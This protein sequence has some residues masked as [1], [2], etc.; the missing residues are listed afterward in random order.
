MALSSL[1]QIDD[2][3]PDPVTADDHHSHRAAPQ[4][5]AL[6]IVLVGASRGPPRSTFRPVFST[7]R[8]LA[9]RT[10]VAV[11][12]ANAL[13]VLAA[14]RGVPTRW[15]LVGSGLVAALFV[16]YT[17]LVG[18]LSW[19]VFPG[20]STASGLRQGVADGSPAKCSTTRCRSGNHTLA[21]CS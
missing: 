3:L 8:S 11:V 9:P 20:P 13:A 10:L 5:R 12:L 1:R 21:S 16:S 2:D 17:I 6:E 4:L 15:S 14:R 19:G 18:T 7:L